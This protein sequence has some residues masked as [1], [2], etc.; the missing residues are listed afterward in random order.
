MIFPVRVIVNHLVTTIK[1]E[2]LRIAYKRH[3]S[4][5]RL[6][7]QQMLIVVLREESVLCALG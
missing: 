5:L 6:A 3:K 4:V 2:L 1:S 7:L